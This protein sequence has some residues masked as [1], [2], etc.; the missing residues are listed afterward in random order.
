ME[1]FL[2]KRGVVRPWFELAKYDDH[3]AEAR[4]ALE[5]AENNERRDGNER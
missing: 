5:A 1:A 4:V 2:N 3:I